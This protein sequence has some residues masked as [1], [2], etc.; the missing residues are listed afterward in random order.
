MSS[1]LAIA[2]VTAVLRDLLNNGLIDQN[3]SGLLGNVIVTTLAPDRIDVTT[4][5]Q[6]SQL[7]LFMYQ[8]TPNAAWRNVGLP[9]RN[10]AGERISNPPLALNLHY[11]LTA[12]GAQDLHAEIL[13]GYG[14]QLFHETPVLPRQAIHTSL[15]NAS[16]VPSGSGLPAEFR[17]LFTSELAEQVEQIKIAPESLN[18][19]EISRMWS[20]MQA[21]YRP[22]AA[23][24][25]SVVLIESKQSFKTALP[26]TARKVYAIPFNQLVI[27]E[28]RSQASSADPI[29]SNQPI[30]PGH[31][32]VLVGR[33]LSADV[34]RV[35]IGG[36]EAVPTEVTGTQII[37][38]LPASL[39][40]GVQPVQVVH[41]KEI[42]EPPTPHRLFDSN[43]AA[44]VLRPVIESANI[45]FTLGPG[46]DP[47]DGTITFRGRSAGWRQSASGTRVEPDRAA[48]ESASAGQWPVV[49]LYCSVAHDREPAVK[50]T[51]RDT[52]LRHPDQR[53]RSRHLPRARADRRRRKS[54][55]RT[56]R[57]GTVRR[58]AG[59]DSMTL[60]THEIWQEA[61]TRYLMARWLAVRERLLPASEESQDPTEKIE[62]EDFEQEALQIAATMSAA[63][64][65]DRLCKEFS[66]SPFER[67]VLLLCAGVELDPEFTEICSQRPEHQHLLNPN[68]HLALANLSGAHWA[69]ITPASPLRHWRFIDVDRRDQTL[70]TSPL[71]LDERILHFLVG[72]DYLDERLANFFQLTPAPRTMP[73][74]YRKHCEKITSLWASDSGEPPIVH[75]TGDWQS[76]KSALA[77]AS[78]AALGLRLHSLNASDIPTNS[79]ERETLLRLWQRESLLLRSALFLLTD[80]ADGESLRLA[81]NFLRRVGGL[82]F[83]SGEVG[84]AGLSAPVVTIEINLPGTNEQRTLWEESL[85]PLAAN[86]NGQLDEVVTQFRFDPERIRSV[87]RAVREDT[88][89]R[90]AEVEKVLWRN[91][92][93]ESRASLKGLAECIEAKAGWDDLILAGRAFAGAWRDRSASPAANESLR[94]VG[95]CDAQRSRPGYHRVV[96]WSKWHRQNACG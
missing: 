93:V 29:V 22:T 78:C 72:A 33:G 65:L 20:A 6:Q 60:S 80:D 37:V 34:V 32:L 73:P 48:G 9:S 24:Q 2:S 3:I 39:K 17:A 16:Q 66:L 85:G 1:A 10:A 57:N 96:C 74:S 53:R 75:L 19:E 63:P 5:N 59:G 18:T 30:L 77:A 81:R 46:D 21:H 7:N 11:M 84:L 87:A 86:L 41:F 44:F 83:V 61:N 62:V 90:P 45:V 50:S 28:I 82:V 70:A 35:V 4:N 67:D 64:T 49:Q 69:A 27:D 68:F 25:A 71:R 94:V 38:P 76:G 43:V 55:D 47:I 52:N 56:C 15:Q 54:V 23:Y 89:D 12:Y 13:L 51:R 88:S 79:V 92:R 58:A 31:N 14:M 95:I 26:V 42:G 40:P 36:V 91:C 8:V